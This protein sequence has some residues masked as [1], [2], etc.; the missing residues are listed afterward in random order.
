MFQLVAGHRLNAHMADMVCCDFP[1]EDELLA[2]GK[3]FTKSSQN[4]KNFR[5]WEPSKVQNTKLPLF[6]EDKS[7]LLSSLKSGN[8]FER[9]MLSSEKCRE[10]WHE[11]PVFRQMYF[12]L[13]QVATYVGVTPKSYSHRA[14]HIFTSFLHRLVYFMDARLDYLEAVRY[15][16]SQRRT[17]VQARRFISH[18]F[19]CTLFEDYVYFTDWSPARINR[20]GKFKGGSKRLIQ[21]RLTKPMDIQVVHPARQPKAKNYCSNH[22]CSHLCVLRPKGYSCRCPYGMHLKKDNKTCQ[23][24]ADSGTVCSV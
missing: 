23:G 9:N 14:L 24:K 1:C 8:L 3:I 13:R 7:R 17:V 10:L 11:N 6:N 21:E 20:V 16:G 22:T 18:P 5:T 4:P 15:D 12:L 19:A 2:P